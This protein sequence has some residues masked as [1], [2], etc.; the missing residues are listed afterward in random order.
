M[1]VLTYENERIWTPRGRPWHLLGSPMEYVD[2]ANVS[3]I[4]LTIP[5]GQSRI[6][7]RR[8]RQPTILPKFSKKLHEIAK[9]LG[10]R[11]GAPPLRSATGE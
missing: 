2:L 10:R 11:G 6:P 3:L 5:W 9:I 1:D 4:M 7:C 8:G